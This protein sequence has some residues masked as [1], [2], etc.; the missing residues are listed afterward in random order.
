MRNPLKLTGCNVFLKYISLGAGHADDLAYLFK[1]EAIKGLRPGSPEEVTVKRLTKL[2]T[3]FA[4]TGNPNPR[5]PDE[6]I[7]IEWEP[8]GKN[9]LNYL[10][11]DKELSIGVNPDAER[12]NFWE[13][14]YENFP[15]AKFW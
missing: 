10:N 1:F 3:N 5:T 12:M 6:L 4:K 15:F 14:L 13:Q 8:V 9:G 11:I 2:W 7:Q